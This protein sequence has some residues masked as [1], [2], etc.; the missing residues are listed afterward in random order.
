MCR[1]EISSGAV[2]GVADRTEAGETLRGPNDLIFSPHGDLYFTDPQGSWDA[3]TGAVYGVAVGTEAAVLVADGLRFPNGLVLSPDGETLLV[4][5]TP[6]HRVTAIALATGQK[7]VFAVVSDVG[8]PDGMRWGPDGSL[9]AA[10]FGGGEV[11]RVSLAGEVTGRLAVPQGSRPTN[12]C[13]S[14]GGTALYVTEAE[15]HSVVR[16]GSPDR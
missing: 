11:V 6:L 12:L 4:A 9:Y 13:F 5:E 2:S 16:F 8:G 1:L 7:K 10:I 14:A 3:P 15:S